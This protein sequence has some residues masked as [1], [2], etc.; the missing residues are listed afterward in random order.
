M[1]DIK[2]LI[3][4]A[5]ELE[6][7]KGDLKESYSFTSINLEN[8]NIESE[9]ADS[10]IT[11]VVI[12][13]NSKNFTKEL[14]AKIDKEKLLV[15]FNPIKVNINKISPSEFRAIKEVQSF[16]QSI[17]N[18]KSFDIEQLKKDLDTKID[19]VKA[20][21]EAELRPQI[22]STYLEAI[23]IKDYFSITDMEIED[24]KDKKEI[25]FVGENGDGK[26]ILLQAIA[27]ALKGQG[28]DYTK[29]AYDYIEE[30]EET[31]ELSTIDEKFPL[32][33][34]G[35][36]D[37][38]NLFAYGINRNKISSDDEDT[39]ETSYSGLFDTPSIY[40]TTLLKDA[41][42][43]LL[44]E[45]PIVDEFKEKMVFLMDKKFQ[46]TKTD[47]GLRYGE[48]EQFSMLSEGYKTTLIWLSDLLSR[49]MENDT[50]NEITKLEDFKAIVLIDEVDLYLHPKWKYD[51]MNKLRDIFPKIQFIMTTH[52]LVTVLG[53][54]EDAVFYKVYKEGKDTKISEQIDDIS[55]YT[56]DILMSSPLF[57]LQTIKSRQFDQREQVSSDDYIYYRIH[58]KIKERLNET[59]SA[60][61]EDVDSWL[62][63]AFDEEFGEE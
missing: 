27:L 22:D 32:E 61:D 39:K 45:H 55:Y 63:D 42:K 38:K 11:L 14:Y 19:E 10:D 12:D 62:D 56:S 59:P 35:Y 34:R 23:K 41:E 44:Q 13:K 57:N 4:L 21:K 9:I 50:E 49:M 47:N 40:R 28:K 53:A 58:K 2:I 3:I 6:S 5:K 30:I 51:F 48:I 29:L 20:K 8:E 1:I 46:I 37:V 60:T 31:M 24:L 25:Y 36:K 17:D 26:T 33:Y 43:F 15:Y 52:S 16:K 7:I 18:A 54:S